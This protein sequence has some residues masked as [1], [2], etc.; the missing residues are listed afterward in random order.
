MRLDVV[1][2]LVA[3]DSGEPVA[4]ELLLEERADRC[5]REGVAVEE[6][7]DVVG[8]GL[9]R[10]R[11]CE[12]VQ[13][14]GVAE[15]AVLEALRRREVGDVVELRRVLAVDPL[16]VGVDEV[17][18]RQVAL[19]VAQLDVDPARVA[20]VHGGDADHRLTASACSL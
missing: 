11:L 3:P 16:E 4:G 6:E 14:L 18:L 19:E 20:P 7:Q 8:R 2:V 10:D 12:R 17:R 5:D 13:L 9:G 1:E 15:D